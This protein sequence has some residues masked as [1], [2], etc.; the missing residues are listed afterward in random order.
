[1][2]RSERATM[3]NPNTESSRAQGERS[4]VRL[5]LECAA[6]DH[7][8]LTARVRD[9]EGERDIYRTMLQIALGQ[10]SRTVAQLESARWSIQALRATRRRADRAA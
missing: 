6:F 5:A 3:A 10:L 9:L 4:V 7:V 2:T 8:E 1:M